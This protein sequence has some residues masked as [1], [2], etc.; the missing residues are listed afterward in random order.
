MILKCVSITSMQRIQGNYP[1]SIMLRVIHEMVNGICAAVQALVGTGA[2]AFF[3]F[4]FFTSAS[5]HT[6]RG[7]TTWNGSA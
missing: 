6:I 2:T 4:L 5:I 3:C 7:I 1:F